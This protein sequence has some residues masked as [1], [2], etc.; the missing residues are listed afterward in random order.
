MFFFQLLNAMKGKSVIECGYVKSSETEAS[1]FAT[2]L[3]LGVS[4]ILLTFMGNL[5]LMIYKSI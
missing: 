2:P 1:Y 3:Q 4:I 5:L